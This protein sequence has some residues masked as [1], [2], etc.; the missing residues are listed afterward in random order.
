VRDSPESVAT[1]AGIAS[2]F[3]FLV[4]AATV[5]TIEAVVDVEEEDTPFRKTCRSRWASMIKKVYE[6]DPLVC[7]KCGGQMRIISF[8]EAKDQMDVIEKI[9]KHCK[10][11]V[12][13]EERAPPEKTVAVPFE[14]VHVP[15]DEFFANF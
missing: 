2:S 10:L 8:I 14:S 7:P 11:W 12:E 4:K 6:I 1:I 3:H 9:L 13:P 5:K 15:I